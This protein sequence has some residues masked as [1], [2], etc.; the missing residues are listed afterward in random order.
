MADRESSNLQP[1]TVATD[2][3]HPN[4]VPRTAQSVPVNPGA[5]VRLRPLLAFLLLVT[6]IVLV[7]VA[8]YHANVWIGLTVT[9]VTCIVLGMAAAY[10]EV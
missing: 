4:G 7:N 6:G 9:G 2:P 5:S 8:A 10:E 3:A 1:F